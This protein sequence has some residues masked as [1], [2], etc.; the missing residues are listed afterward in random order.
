[1]VPFVPT[2]IAYPSN[3][4]NFIHNIAFRTLNSRANKNIW[5]KDIEYFSF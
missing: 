3:T 5:I 1:M 4:V 2:F